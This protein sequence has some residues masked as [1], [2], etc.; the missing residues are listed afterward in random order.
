MIQTKS[1]LIGCAKFG[2]AGLLFWLF[3]SH[4]NSDKVLSELGDIRPLPLLFAVLGAFLIQWVT[5]AQM[6]LGLAPFGI[7][8]SSWRLFRIT[9]ISGF[10]SMVAPGGM[11]AGGVATWYKMAK[12][13]G[14]AIEAGAIVVYFRLVNTLLLVLLGVVGAMMD[15]RLADTSM[16]RALFSLLGLTL[17]GVIPLVVPAVGGTVHRGMDGLTSGLR[18]GKLKVL[19]QKFSNVFGTFHTLGKKRIAGVFGYG[20][21]INACFLAVW[22]AIGKAVT[23]SVS[24]FTLGWM[25]AVQGLLQLVQVTPG[26]LGVRDVT[27]VELLQP[28]GVSTEHAL[29]LS[30]TAFLVMLIGAF[31]GGFFELQDV[32]GR[33]KAS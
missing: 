3:C 22:V 32:F 12:D 10:Y 17:C 30:A 16:Q 18:D 11:V 33:K 23:V 6:H 26:G 1:V 5:A 19:L 13:S 2:F 9:L 14:K 21:L 29:A 27:L 28:Y 31:A 7:Q 8:L 25:A 15:P 20:V 24:A 4:A